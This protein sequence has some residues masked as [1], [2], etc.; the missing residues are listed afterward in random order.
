MQTIPKSEAVEISG[1][2]VKTFDNYFKS[3]DE[4][5]SLPR[6]PGGRYFF[7]KDKII[8]WRNDYERRTIKLTLDDYSLCLDF[9]LAQHFRGYVMSDWGT[10]RQREFGQKITNWVKGQLGEVAVQKFLKREFD[11]DISLDFDIHKKI[12]P[13]DIIAVL[14]NKKARNPRI[15]IGIKSSKPKNAYLVLSENEI[16]IAGR[17]SDVY[18]YCRPDIPDDHLLRITR[19]RV[20]E[21]IK[22]EP[23]Y[24]SYRE[25][26]PVFTDI[27]CEIAGWCWVHELSKVTSIPGQPFDGYRYVIKSGLLHRKKEDWEDLLS[28]L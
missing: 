12:V 28:H 26:I 8:Q 20:I 11:T 4:F 19:D 10:G 16:E 21:L 1:L 14:E 25:K 3:A 5:L 17:K 13:Q 23:H 18:I 6:V 9:A 22:G 2:D 15:G 7:D 27:Q 24:P